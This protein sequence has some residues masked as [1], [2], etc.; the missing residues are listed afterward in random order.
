MNPLFSQR[1]LSKITHKL[2]KNEQ[3]IVVFAIFSSIF[4]FGLAGLSD[5]WDFF[6][7]PL[8]VTGDLAIWWT[9]LNQHWQ[10]KLYQFAKFLLSTSAILALILAYL[11]QS[12]AYLDELRARLFL[13]NH[14]I[15]AG[16]NQRSIILAAD[17]AHQG[18]SV[19]IITL[20]SKYDETLEI[21]KTGVCVLQGDATNPAVLRSAGFQH[22]RN[23][24]CITNQDDINIA[25]LE[26]ARILL[27]QHAATQKPTC[28]CH[29]QSPLLRNHLEQLTIM[30]AQGAGHRF[31]LFSIEENTASELLRRFPPE[32][33]LALEQQAE[34]VHVAFLGRTELAF[35]LALQMAQSC[36]YWRADYQAQTM[37]RAR[38]TIIS[39]DAEKLLT[40][41]RQLCPAID[42]VLIIEAVTEAPDDYSILSAWINTQGKQLSQFYVGL[43]DE[44]T[45]LASA[46]QVLKLLKNQGL[47][48]P[49]K[50][51]AV[52][53]LRPHPIKPRFWGVDAN[54]AVLETL[55][56]CQSDVL[57]SGVNDTLAQIAHQDY[58]DQALRNGKQLGERPA[59]AAWDDLNE[60]LRAGTRQQIA[61]INIKLRALGWG[62]VKQHAVDRDQFLAAISAEQLEQIAEMEHRRWWAFHLIHGWTYAP[63]RDDSNLHHD[64]LLPYQQL[65]EHVKQYDRSTVQNIPELC[66]KAGNGLRRL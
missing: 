47:D 63:K 10:E 66:R 22:A 43:A 19:V 12:G 62:L 35:M 46:G 65:S 36:H 25:M 15:I 49:G 30:G 26:A 7:H 1:I 45:T 28:F 41:I 33:H 27:D 61:H 14:T 23:F 48:K 37:P 52:M 18:Q 51:V 44:I 3:N 31:R 6:H 59:L 58:L 20:D 57:L 32:R 17:L 38:L 4:L 29:I 2:V 21:R 5:I 39:P 16:M 11:R 55:K 64:C 8:V 34:G 9:W 24:V 50:V 40:S 60:F 13:R 56:S 54:L 42:N 53:P